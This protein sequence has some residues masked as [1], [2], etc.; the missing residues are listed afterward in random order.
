MKTW[1]IF[2]L[3]ALL[4]LVFLNIGVQLGKIMYNQDREYE[5]SPPIGEGDL[6]TPI[7][8]PFTAVRRSDGSWAV[9]LRYG[10]NAS[11]R[12]VDVLFLGRSIDESE[13]TGSYYMESRY[14]GEITRNI[15]MFS[16]TGKVVVETIMIRG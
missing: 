12:K 7:S 1:Q 16:D 2:A 15:T 8:G 14:K 3:L 5:T 9:D 4:A 13:M 10:N 6:P 11:W